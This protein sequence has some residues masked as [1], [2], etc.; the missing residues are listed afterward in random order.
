MRKVMWSAAVSLDL[1]LAGPG[2][3]L[4]WL[5][6]SDDAAA[7]GAASWQGVDTLLMGRKTYDFAARSGGGGEAGG[8]KIRT[9]IFSR[10]ITEAPAGA[11]LVAGDAAAFVRRLKQEEGGAIMVMGGG[12]LAGALI[13]GGAVDEIGLNVHPLL[14]GGGVPVFRP[15]ARRVA[16]ALV[17]ARPIARDC[18][19]LRY[20]L[21]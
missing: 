8:A 7:I 3:A 1:Y 11:E 21:A 13:E 12:A 19:F 9:Y 4:D 20:R 10:T 16:L 5:L 2:E 18:L 17:E 6:W 15:I 14:L